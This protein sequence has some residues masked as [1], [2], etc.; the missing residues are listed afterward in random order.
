MAIIALFGATGK[1]GSEILKQ[2][3]LAGHIV[4][5]LVRRKS[6]YKIAN[7]FRESNVPL[8]LQNNVTIVKGDVITEQGQVH[9]TCMGVDI[10]IS[11]LNEDT[12]SSSQTD[13]PATLNEIQEEEEIISLQELTRIVADE[14]YVAGIARFIII[15]GAGVLHLG[16]DDGPLLCDN[17][18]M[19]D[20]ERM[21]AVAQRHKDNLKTMEDY[22]FDWTMACPGN[23]HG[24]GG[25]AAA[26]ST[27]KCVG[28][29]FQGPEFLRCTYADCAYYIVQEINEKKYIKKK[30]A[31]ASPEFVQQQ[32]QQ[33]QESTSIFGRVWNGLYNTFFGS[34][35]SKL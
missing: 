30:M 6:V 15:G 33:Q 26:P 10:V 28:N 8:E 2:A 17:G 25:V 21:Q 4:K 5:I 22:L 19:K 29:V 1:L 24:S 18:P 7:I 16:A 20:N 31:F 12:P 9:E 14:A 13:I 3:L 35:S 27:S 34:S 32:Q 23:M 11:T